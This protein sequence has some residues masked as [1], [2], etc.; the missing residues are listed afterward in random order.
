MSETDY[1]TIVEHPLGK[2]VMDQTLKEPIP[3]VIYDAT[4]EELLRWIPTL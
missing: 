4:K 1:E 3:L 2:Y